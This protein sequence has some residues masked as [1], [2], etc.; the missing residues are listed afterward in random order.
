[1]NG[2]RT[3]ILGKTSQRTVTWKMILS[4]K[5]I[6]PILWKLNYGHDNLLECYFETDKELAGSSFAKKPILSREGANIQLMKQG[7]MLAETSGEYGE[8]GYI[9]QALCT[10]P[11]FSG[12]YPLIGSWVVGQEAAGIGIRESRNLITDNSSRFV[13]HLIL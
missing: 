6:L 4:S 2:W 9:Y 10:L 3:K 11:D 1:M 12:N 8:E 7:T 13:P 5:A